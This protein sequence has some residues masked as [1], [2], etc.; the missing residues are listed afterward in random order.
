[1]ANHT[2]IINEA[3]LTSLV[4]DLEALS[5]AAK[6]IK[7]KLIKLLPAKYGSDL[8]WEKEIKDGIES[9]KSGRGKKFQ[10]YQEAI[11]Y[12]NT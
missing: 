10:T 9:I 8:W 2:K 5:R 1:M 3:T 7:E 6:S 11:K 4:D 12:L